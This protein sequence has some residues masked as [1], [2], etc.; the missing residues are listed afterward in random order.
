M[1][2]GTKSMLLSVSLTIFS[3]CV[4][5]SDT[6][7]HREAVE[8]LFDLTR[9][10]HKIETSVDNVVAMQLNQDPA[11]RQHEALF[12]DYMERQIGWSGLKA[13]LTDMYMQ[14]FTEQELDEINAFYSSPAGSKLIEKL[15]ELIKR[16]DRL[17]MQRMQDNIS[18]LKQAIEKAS[19]QP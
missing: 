4:L 8:K 1:K 3:T 7:S 2:T 14:A 9:M 6:N 10:Q 16:R 12:R 15:P 11:M 5:A 18:E 19:S 17:A 13:P